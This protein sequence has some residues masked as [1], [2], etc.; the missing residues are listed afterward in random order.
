MTGRLSE[1]LKQAGDLAPVFTVAPDTYQRARRA[2]RRDLGLAVVSSVAAVALIAGIVTSAAAREDA[3]PLP[4]DGQGPVGVPSVVYGIPSDADLG[5]ASSDLAVGRSAVSQLTDDEEPVVI[6]D[7]GGYHL[8]DLPGFSR[9]LHMLSLSPDGRQLAWGWSESASSAKG[10][11]FGVRIADLDSGEVREVAIETGTS[12]YVYDFTWSPDGRWLVWEGIGAGRIAPG[13]VV[14][15]PVP[16]PGDDNILYAV[17]DSGV[18]SIATLKALRVWDGELL[19]NEVRETGWYPS[20]STVADGVLVETI[21]R[22]RDDTFTTRHRRLVDGEV[23]EAIATLDDRSFVSDLGW[24]DARQALVL[25]VDTPASGVGHLDVLDLSDPEDTTSYRVGEVRGQG[26]TVAADLVAADRPGIERPAQAW[27]VDE[28]SSSSAA[29]LAI[30]G[31]G[32]LV[33]VAGLGWWM[34][35]RRA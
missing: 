21:Q 11:P 19:S 14:S 10:T 2:R 28:D 31:A 23:V 8:L 9:P 35:R 33:V 7:R 32:G 34:R 17:D 6:D 13:Q 29:M 25:T 15:E 27:V 5:P 30:G 26:V 20:I 12:P 1:E 4:A 22:D 3:G 24:V 18:V 16:R